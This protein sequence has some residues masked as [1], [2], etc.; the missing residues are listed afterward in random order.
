M[1]L[2]KL[3]LT[4]LSKQRPTM[5]FLPAPDNADITKGNE[6]FNPYP[7]KTFLDAQNLYAY[8]L[9]FM[10]KHNELPTLQALVA[11]RFNNQELKSGITLRNEN[12]ESL[13]VTYHEEFGGIVVE[14]TTNSTPLIRAVDSHFSN[15]PPPWIAFPK[16]DPVE[17]QMNKQGKLEYWWSRIWL[18]FWSTRTPI[19]KE[20]YLVG[21]SATADWREVLL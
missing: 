18:P 1:N 13:A 6:R 9:I 14:A 17:I 12:Q 16:M 19:E 7:A 2:I 4:K 3:I 15:P 8:Y 10:L 21:N 5:Y 11:S 20:Q